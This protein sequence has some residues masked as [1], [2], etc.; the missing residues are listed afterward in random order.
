[1]TILNI[2]TDHSDAFT[3]I[4]LLVV[5]VVIGILAV[6]TIVSY[7]GISQKANNAAMQSAIY[8]TQQNNLKCFKQRIVVIQTQ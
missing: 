6:I 2:E 5:I 7:T 3:I 1:M 8:P 4:E